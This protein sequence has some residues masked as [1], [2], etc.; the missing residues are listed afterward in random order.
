MSLDPPVAVQANVKVKKWESNGVINTVM[1]LSYF[2]ILLFG[3]MVHGPW[4]VG[5]LDTPRYIL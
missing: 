5:I 2:P 3:G 1:G 4:S